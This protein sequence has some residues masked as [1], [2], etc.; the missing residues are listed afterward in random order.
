MS[1][2][3]RIAE[4]ISFIVN[5]VNSQPTLQEIARHIHLSPFHF[6]RLFSRWAGV[7]P[8]RFLQVLTLERAKQLLSES[9]SL[10]EVSDSLGLSSGSR[11]YDHFVHLEAVTP[12]EYKKG[13]VGLS[14]EYGAHD[15]PFGK[16]FI[17]ITPR[18]ICS[19]AFLDGTET[20]EHLIGLQKKWPHAMV[21]ENCRRTL[22]LIKAMFGNEIKLDH[23]VSLHVSGTNFQVSVWKALLQIPPAKVVSYSQVATAIGHPTSARAVGLAVGA[24]P[25]AILIPCHR[26]I[27]QSGKLGG[28]HWGE[29]RKQAIHLWESA[30]YE[31]PEL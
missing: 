30:R 25:V 15:T 23:P 3:D 6:Q 24:N 4:A 26:V 17:A 21:H 13:G 22:V 19:F 2:Y 16:A 1:D 12:G 11:L 20:D 9:K 29:T 31:Q 7:T 5:R 28:Y 14:I 18:G 8:K 10:F 27:Q